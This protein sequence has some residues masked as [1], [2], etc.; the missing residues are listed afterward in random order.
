MMFGNWRTTF[1]IIMLH[2]G[3]FPGEEKAVRPMK[4]LKVRST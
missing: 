2:G 3:R 1:E 4:V